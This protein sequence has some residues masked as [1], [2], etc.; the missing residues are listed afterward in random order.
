MRKEQAEAIEESRALRRR[1]V[2]ALN[3]ASIR[4]GTPLRAVIREMQTASPDSVEST[5]ASGQLALS[6]MRHRNTIDYLTQRVTRSNDIGQSATNALR[7]AVYEALWLNVPPARL[8]RYYSEWLDPWSNAVN[9]ALAENLD[10][11]PEKMPLVNRLSLTL[12][13]PTFLVQTLLDNMK[14]E[15]AVGLMRALNGPRRY[16]VRPNRLQGGGASGGMPLSQATQLHLDKYSAAP[17]VLEQDPTIPHIWEV[18]E[19][20]HHLIGSQGFKAG[21]VIVQDKASVLAVDSLCADVGDRVWDACAAPGMKTQLLAERVGPDGVV[22]ASDIYESRIHMARQES[23]RLG[24]TQVQWIRA[25][26]SSPAVSEADKIL[27]DA[28]CTSTGVLQTYPSFKWR[29]NKKTLFALMTVQNKI[30]DG[31]LTRFSERPGTEI[32]YSTCSILPH[33]GESQVDSA[34]SRHNVELLEPAVPGSTGYPGFACSPKVRRLFPHIHGCNGFFI[35][36]LR[37]MQ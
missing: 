17:V 26:A 6:V 37:V 30:L 13:H 32:V 24:A 10:D 22:I 1:A 16:Y 3:E 15:D 8:M 5:S 31:I 21:E 12:S 18:K 25:D 4:S 23:A 28:P 7:L 19:G 14:R 20:I 36:R 29:L 11:L 35:A 33:E 34:L 2:T 27:I 9:E